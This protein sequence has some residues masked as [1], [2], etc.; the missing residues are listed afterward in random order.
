M[1]VVVPPHAMPRV[2]SSGPSVSEGCLGVRHDPVG[3]VRVGLDAARRDDLAR[4]VD[5]A[6]GLGGQR[7]GRADHRDPLALTPTS[8]R[9]DALRRDDLPVADHEIEHDRSLAQVR[10]AV[11]ASDAHARAGR[12]RCHAVARS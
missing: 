4:R 8:Q 10:A 1:W 7:A 9:P 2:S 11:N 12:R 6:R 5:D 3:Q